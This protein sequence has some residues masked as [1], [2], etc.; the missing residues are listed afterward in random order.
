MFWKSPSSRSCG[1]SASN[2]DVGVSLGIIV[3]VRGLKNKERSNEMKTSC[4]TK[5]TPLLALRPRRI[6]LCSRCDLLR[7]LGNRG[8]Q[9]Q[10]EGRRLAGGLRSVASPNQYQDVGLFLGK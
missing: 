6:A 5:N 7:F 9:D 8:R 3:K 2:D 4:Q 10:G 1:Y